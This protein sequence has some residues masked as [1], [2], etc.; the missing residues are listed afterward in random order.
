MYPDTTEAN[1]P[2]T[3]PR[4]PAGAPLDSPLDSA[5]DSAAVAVTFLS[6]ETATEVLKERYL[7][8]L[9]RSLADFAARREHNRHYSNFGA[10]D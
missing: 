2:A 6:P 4:A 1:R 7:G 9:R 10:P 3:D 5:V 8:P